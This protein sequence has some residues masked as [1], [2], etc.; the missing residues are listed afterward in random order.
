MPLPDGRVDPDSEAEVSE[1]LAAV[2]RALGAGGVADLVGR[3]PGTRFERGRP[4]GAFRA[5]RADR[6]LIGSENGFLVTEPPVL[7]QVVGGVVLHREVLT[8]GKLPAALAG[9]L[10]R[11]NREMGAEAD[12]STVFTAAAEAVQQ[13]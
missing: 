9:T 13:L 12:A 1:V 10:I 8:P 5:A 6:V 11:H 2:N 7:E 3:L 4:G